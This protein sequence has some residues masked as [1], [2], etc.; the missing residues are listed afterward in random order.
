MATLV[1]KRAIL[2]PCRCAALDRAKLITLAIQRAK[3]GV[4]LIACRRMGFS[5]G[6]IKHHVK[7]ASYNMHRHSVINTKI[8]H[9]PTLWLLPGPER[10]GDLR[11]M[12]S[13]HDLYMNEGHNMP[14]HIT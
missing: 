2:Q 8:C 13:N 10:L 9:F 4:G 1:R 7:L 3:A 12:P 5:T 11:C 14:V 6:S